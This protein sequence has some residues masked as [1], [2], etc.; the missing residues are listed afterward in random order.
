MSDNRLIVTR[1]LFALLGLVAGAAAALYAHSVSSSWW[2]ALFVGLMVMYTLGRVVLDL[3]TDQQKGRRALFFGIPVLMAV[4]GVAGAYALWSEWWLA[5]LI[6]FAVGGIGSVIAI[7]AFPE[8]AEEEQQD[9]LARSGGGVPQFASSPVQQV[10]Q[11][12]PAELEELFRAARESGITFT[13]DE[14]RRITLAFYAGDRDEIV[15][16]VSAK[17]A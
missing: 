12:R 4:A 3:I 6:G 10:Q 17:A 15:R 11:A 2:L 16:L 1:N 7:L 9:S 13:P 8:I 14:E 5:V